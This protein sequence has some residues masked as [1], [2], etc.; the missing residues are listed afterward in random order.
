MGT[1]AYSLFGVTL[2]QTELFQTLCH[3]GANSHVDIHVFDARLG[4]F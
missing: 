1:G 2:H 3:H 4:Y